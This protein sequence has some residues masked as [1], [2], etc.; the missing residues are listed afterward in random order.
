M[1]TYLNVK[2]T[3]GAWEKENVS[4][5]SLHVALI[6]TSLRQWVGVT[7]RKVVDLHCEYRIDLINLIEIL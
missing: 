1:H 4:R 7:N 6:T 5:T 2:N 3:R